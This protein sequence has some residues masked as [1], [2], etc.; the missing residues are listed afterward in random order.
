MKSETMVSASLC[1]ASSATEI[2]MDISFSAEMDVGFELEIVTGVEH[3]AKKQLEIRQIAILFIKLNCLLQSH[4]QA[5]F[6]FIIGWGVNNQS[7]DRA[8][9]GVMA[10]AINK[11]KIFLP[12]LEILLS[13]SQI[14]L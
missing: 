8:L 5:T 1:S 7:Y 11:P 13:N 10:Q 3:E 4:K 9:P 14:Q 12:V 6:C 2:V